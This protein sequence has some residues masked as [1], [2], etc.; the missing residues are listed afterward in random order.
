[1]EQDDLDNYG[2]PTNAFDGENLIE[3]YPWTPTNNWFGC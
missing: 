3:T 2:T 1:M